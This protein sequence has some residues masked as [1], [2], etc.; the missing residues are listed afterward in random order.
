MAGVALGD[1]DLHFVW[2]AWHLVTSA[3]TLSG[4]R[5]TYGTGLSHTQLSLAQSLFHHLHAT[6]T[7]IPTHTHN[8]LT[9]NLFTHTHT[10]LSHTQLTPTALSHTALSYVPLSHNLSSTISTQLT[11]TFSDTTCGARNLLKRN[12]LTRNSHTY[13]FHTICLPPSP[14][15]SLLL[16]QI[17]G[18][19]LLTHNLLTQNFTRSV[20]HH[21]LSLSCLSHPVFTLLLLLIGRLD[22]WGYPVL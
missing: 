11:H 8:S 7:H 17:H 9:H 3:C 1:I 6:H 5:G 19:N 12:S 22:M 13:L 18:I 16:F 2:H 14:Q 10:Q 4:R 21:L 20:F 15:N